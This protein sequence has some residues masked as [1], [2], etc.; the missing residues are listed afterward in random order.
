MCR[1]YSFPFSSLFPC[2]SL[3]ALVLRSPFCTF[4]CYAR[5]R[6]FSSGR[7][8]KSVYSG[9][10][11]SLQ[12]LVCMWVP[13]CVGDFESCCFPNFFSPTYLQSLGCV[14]FY[15]GRSIPT[16]PFRFLFLLGSSRLPLIKKRN[17]CCDEGKRKRKDEEGVE[18][19]P[20]GVRTRRLLFPVLLTRSRGIVFVVPTFVVSWPKGDE[21]KEQK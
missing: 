8:Q 10:R 1:S 14:H 16:I 15:S 2:S 13:A 5:G 20:L 11:A 3:R 4:D 12:L 6:Q 9:A 18:L 7:R 21:K 19:V 17:R